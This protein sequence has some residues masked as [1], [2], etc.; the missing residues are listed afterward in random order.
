MLAH[1]LDHR[2]EAKAVPAVRVVKNGS[3]I[4]ASVASSMPRPVSL[5]AMQI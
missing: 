5:T 2:R 4:R 3:K 1:D